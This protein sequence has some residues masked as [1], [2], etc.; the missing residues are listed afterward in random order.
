MCRRRPVFARLYRTIASAQYPTPSPGI[1]NTTWSRCGVVTHM[2]GQHTCVI[3]LLTCG[4]F[5]SKC[6]VYP[7]LSYG[8]S[9]IRSISCTLR[10]TQSSKIRSARSQEHWDTNNLRLTCSDNQD[11]G[12][13][14]CSPVDLRVHAGTV[15]IDKIHMTYATCLL[16]LRRELCLRTRL[17]SPYIVLNNLRKLR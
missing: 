15:C 12:N 14:E 7:P 17:E 3:F 2:T 6:T 16:Y 10:H 9:C 4:W 1:G 8:I 13:P 5:V 11:L